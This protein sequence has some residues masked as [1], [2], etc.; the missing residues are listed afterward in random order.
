MKEK[1]K[2]KIEKKSEKKSEKKRNATW[3][4]YQKLIGTGEILDMKAVL[5]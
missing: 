5:K 4:A 1:E 3:Y 2:I